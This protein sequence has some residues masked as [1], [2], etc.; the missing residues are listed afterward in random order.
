MARHEWQP[1]LLFGTAFIV[2][3]ATQGYVDAVAVCG[4]GIFV[5]HHDPIPRVVLI[6]DMALNANITRS[7]R[8]GFRVKQTI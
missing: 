7:M 6:L 3:A 4:R 1:A 8:D 5:E 2:L